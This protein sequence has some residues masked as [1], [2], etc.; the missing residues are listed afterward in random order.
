MDATLWVFRL[1]YKDGR[2]EIISDY[3][4]DSSRNADQKKH[5]AISTGQ[6]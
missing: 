4:M 3:K 5:L 6:F 1:Q 2:H